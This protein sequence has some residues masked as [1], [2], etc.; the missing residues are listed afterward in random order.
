MYILLSQY[1]CAIHFNDLN[2]QPMKSAEKNLDNA[3]KLMLL[4]G[5]SLIHDGLQFINWSEIPNEQAYT[6]FNAK[7]TH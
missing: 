3:Q 5:I 2:V 6:N 4:Q 7:V 1:I